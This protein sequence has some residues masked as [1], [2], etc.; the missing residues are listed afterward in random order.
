MELNKVGVQEIS[1]GAATTYR[2]ASVI[3]FYNPE[4]AAPYL[5]VTEITKGLPDSLRSNFELQNS[6][7]LTVPFDPDLQIPMYNPITGEPTGTNIGV[8]ELL[9]FTYSLYMYARAT[10]QTQVQAS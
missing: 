8:G 10:A 1:V 4:N 5:A 9:A 3:A 2:A 7:N 6:V